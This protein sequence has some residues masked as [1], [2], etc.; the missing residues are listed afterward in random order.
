MAQVR[1]VQ[2]DGSEKCVEVQRDVSVM[3]AAVRSGIRG[4][5]G[6]CGGCLDCATCHV[7]VDEGQASS[8]PPPSEEELELL[9]AV[10]GERKPNSRLSCQLKVLAPLKE[11]VVRVPARQS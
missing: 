11:L 2:H 3:L 6:E 9:S 10:S 4:I 7:Y 8:V 5:D 1:F